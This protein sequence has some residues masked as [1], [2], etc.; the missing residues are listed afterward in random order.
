MKAR[1]SIMAQALPSSGKIAHFSQSVTLRISGPALLGPSAY[2]CY[3][4][5]AALKGQLLV[6]IFYGNR[7]R[8][9]RV[10]LFGL[11]Q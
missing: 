5:M 9:R 8:S 7:D 4:F 6:L 11:F 10:V 1:M 2:A 3:V